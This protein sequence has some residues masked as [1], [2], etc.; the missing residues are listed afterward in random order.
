V[1]L[2]FVLIVAL[3]LAILTDLVVLVGGVVLVLLGR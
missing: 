2:R 1:V 3:L